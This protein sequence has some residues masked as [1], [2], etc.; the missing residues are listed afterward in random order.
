[1]LEQP[2]RNKHTRGCVRVGYSA[3]EN[4]SGRFVCVSEGRG[5]EMTR[6]GSTA[7]PANSYRFRQAPV[8]RVTHLPPDST[9]TQLRGREKKREQA[10]LRDEENIDSP[11]SQRQHSSTIINLVE[12]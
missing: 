5:W 8:Y 3:G 6:V 10:A 11:F 7:L 4:G 9:H 2:T 1:M 12:S